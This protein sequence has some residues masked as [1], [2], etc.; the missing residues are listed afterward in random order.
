M[1]ASGFF[2]LERVRTTQTVLPLPK[3]H[4]VLDPSF[5]ILEL[6]QKGSGATKYVAK[7]GSYFS[8][9]LKNIRLSQ[10]TLKLTFSLILQFN[11]RLGATPYGVLGITIPPAAAGIHGF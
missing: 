4:T 8:E 7:K 5:Q 2:I 3:C 11:I 9:Y 6:E 10:K 1:T